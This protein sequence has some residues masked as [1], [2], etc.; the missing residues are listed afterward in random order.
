HPY[1][2]ATGTT[3]TNPK[4]YEQELDFPTLEVRDY[5]SPQEQATGK[6]YFVRDG[7]SHRIDFAEE[8]IAGK[9]IDELKK[10]V[11]GPAKFQLSGFV[12]EFETP[13]NRVEIASGKNRFGLP[14]TRINYKTHEVTQNA[15]MK[16][17]DRLGEVLTKMGAGNSIKNTNYNP[18][19]DHTVATCRM[20][21]TAADG[22]VDGNL[23]IHDCDNV[24]V[25]SNAVFPN[26]AA[27][28]PTLTL[29]ALAIRFAET[30]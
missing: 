10:Q 6:M 27:V 28:N 11:T 16:A 30:V 23:K 14:R 5:D 24:F 15:R 20:S 4:A 2:A 25:V 3:P 22:V 21:A 9:K 12:E 13:G 7:R 26:V 8:L 17:V 19:A 18:R 1:I 29:T